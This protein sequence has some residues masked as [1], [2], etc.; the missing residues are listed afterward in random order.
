[1]PIKKRNVESIKTNLAY[2]GNVVSECRA[3]LLAADLSLEDCEWLTTRVSQQARH[4]EG[5]IVAL[6]HIAQRKRADEAT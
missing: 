5:I 3:G 4:L 6:K 1:M 2:A